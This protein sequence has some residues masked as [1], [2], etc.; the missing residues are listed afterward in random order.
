MNALRWKQLRGGVCIQI[1]VDRC[2]PLLSG[3]ASTEFLT[4]RGLRGNSNNHYHG[5]SWRSIIRMI[6]DGY[7]AQRGITA[8]WISCPVENHE[9]TYHDGWTSYHGYHPRNFFL[10]NHGYGSFE[11]FQ[12]LIR[13]AHS[14]VP[15]I[16]IIIDFVPNHT[17]RGAGRLCV[18]RS[19]NL[20]GNTPVLVA[21]ME[22]FNTDGEEIVLGS[23]ND[24][25]CPHFT[26]VGGTGADPHADLNARR[27]QHIYQPFADLGELNQQDYVVDKILKDAAVAWLS[28]GVDGLRVDAAKH[29]AHGWLTS[30]A[31]HIY[32]NCSLGH[33][34]HILSPPIIFGEYIYE[35]DLRDDFRYFVKESGMGILNFQLTGAF[36][37]RGTNSVTSCRNEVD[38]AIR[39]YGNRVHDFVN[40]IDNHDMKRFMAL[41]DASQWKFDRRM[42]ML[43]TV[44]GIPMVY[45]NTEVYGTEE[46]GDLVTLD[47]N[48]RMTQIIQRLSQLRQSSTALKY[49]NFTV[50]YP[51]A[52]NEVNDILV[53]SRTFGDQTVIVG[54]NEG[55][56]NR[57]I[58]YEPNG[59]NHAP[60]ECTSVLTGLF[61]ANCAA[62]TVRADG[63]IHNSNAK[64][65]TIARKTCHVWS[66]KNTATVAPTIGTVWP[67]KTSRNNL[68]TIQGKGFTSVEAF[69]L[70]IG[71]DNDMT[72][73][74]AIEDIVDVDDTTITC[75]I[76]QVTPH[77]IAVV[78]VMYTISMRSTAG[79]ALWS[80]LKLFSGRQICVR[81]F[82]HN[83]PRMYQTNEFSLLLCGDIPELGT[84]RPDDAHGRFMHS[85]R[86]IVGDTNANTWFCDV[87]LPEMRDI[88]VKAVVKNHSSGQFVWQNG[89]NRNIRTYSAPHTIELSWS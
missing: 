72:N 38:S 30:F 87:N 80:G 83:V 23:T 26:H 33:N 1:M 65:W 25:T 22:R 5:G 82:I 74:V 57:T 2:A 39:H 62:I 12:E 75:R 9:E 64:T 43:M 45:Y 16:M 29:M 56:H 53:F 21:D 54:W 4:N 71:L 88:Q 67:R 51:P 19:Y 70:Y 34:G 3:D 61:D 68:I 14:Q 6:L 60:Q 58:H 44:P 10:P 17:S 89:N 73:A 52:N 7:F 42:V 47:A 49:G 86:E 13:V 11:D 66:L 20:H 35:H 32:D 48:T 15:S 78:D 24:R 36:R 59:Q 37:R 31:S 81:V 18:P 27:V 41:E 55:D 84:W 69:N 50:L 63:A 28:C 79:E 40:F 85:C 76:P 46:R 8:M 77:P